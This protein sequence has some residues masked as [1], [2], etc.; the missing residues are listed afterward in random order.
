MS[1]CGLWVGLGWT[2]LGV[3]YMFPRK[4]STA[5]FGYKRKPSGSCQH[6]PQ[7]EYE[8]PSWQK[9]VRP[10]IAAKKRVPHVLAK[11]TIH[12]LAYI[13][14]ETHMGLSQMG[15]RQSRLACHETSQQTLSTGLC[16]CSRFNWN[17]PIFLR[18]TSLQIS[19]AVHVYWS[20][21]FFPREV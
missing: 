20:R 4:Q 7:S 5:P 3:P 9:G 14:P 21:G 12:G 15:L 11:S 13:W 19:F 10:T 2:P 18:G 1:W 17:K 8:F 16:V 6:E